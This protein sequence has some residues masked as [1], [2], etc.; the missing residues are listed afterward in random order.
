MKWF[1]G[2]LITLYISLSILLGLI[3]GLIFS[4]VD[5]KITAMH[6][7]SLLSHYNIEEEE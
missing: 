3:S 7:T 5:D 1:I 2:G 6:R 4:V